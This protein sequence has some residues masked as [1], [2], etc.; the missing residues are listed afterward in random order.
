VPIR[1]VAARSMTPIATATASANASFF[2]NHYT[3]A[4]SSERSGQ[5]AILSVLQSQRPAKPTLWSS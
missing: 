5:R 1:P 3:F 2:V 4:E